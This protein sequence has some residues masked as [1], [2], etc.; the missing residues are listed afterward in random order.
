MKNHATIDL[1]APGIVL[2]DPEV[3]NNFLTEKKITET[4][5]FEF[6]LQHETLGR[7]AIEEGVICPIYQ[8][9]EDEYSVFLNDTSDPK[10]LLH[11]I[12]FSYSGFPL[13]I[14]S[15]ILIVSD[16]NA[17]FDWDFEFFINYKLN[18]EQR[19]PSN[20][21]IDVLSGLYSMTIKGCTELK[22]PYA[23]LGYGLELM[24]VSKLPMVDTST[25]VDD[26]EFSLY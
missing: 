23:N 18:Y 26:H 4:N 21:Y 6:F 2:F 16:L 3:L 24:P 15:G 1:Y 20:D 9:P 11:E 7:L 12:K 17:L 5:I 8:I 10:K 13:E 19:L 22:P 25:S 14:T